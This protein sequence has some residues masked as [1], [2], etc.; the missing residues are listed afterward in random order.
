MDYAASHGGHKAAGNGRRRQARTRTRTSR[1]S[2]GRA[3]GEKPDQRGR[4]TSGRVARILYGQ[5]Y[6]FI[7]IDDRRDVFFHRKDVSG[8]TFN[9]LAVDDRVELELIDDALTGPRGI[10]LIRG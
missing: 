7:R 3:K 1:L 9:E 5:G 2:T 4:P 8:G 10:R 6:G